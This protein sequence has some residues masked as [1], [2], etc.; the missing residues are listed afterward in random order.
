[1]PY[2]RDGTATH[3]DGSAGFAFSRANFLPESRDEQQPLIGGGGRFVMLFDGRID[4]REDLIADLDVTAGLARAPDCMV[5]M[6]CWEAWGKRLTSRLIG[7]FA[8]IVWDRVEHCLF[9]ARDHLGLRPLS[10]HVSPDVVVISNVPNALFASGLVQRE[11]DRQ[12][13]ADVLVENYKDPVR[14]LFRHVE[15]VP[16]AHWLTVSR[17]TVGMERYWSLNPERSIRLPRDENYVEAADELLRKAVAP[18][19]RSTGLVGSEISS[20]LDSPSIAVTALELLGP[21]RKL[22]VFTLVPEPTWRQTPHARHLEDEAP[23]VREIAHMHPNMEPCFLPAQGVPSD[24]GTDDRLRHMPMLPRSPVSMSV[25]HDVYE[26]AKAR[27]VTTLLNGAQGNL[28][29]SWAGRGAYNEWLRAGQLGKLLGELRL[30]ARSPLEMIRRFFGL[31]VIPGAPA[32]MQRL[33]KRL[34]GGQSP[35]WG[36]WQSFSLINPDFAAHMRVEERAADLGWNFLDDYTDLRRFRADMLTCD[37]AQEFGDFYLGLE[38]LHGITTRLPLLDVRLVEWC[39][40]LPEEQFLQHGEGR[41]LIK[42]LMKNRLPANVLNDRRRGLQIAD[43]HSS[44]TRDLPRLKEQLE[45]IAE[46]PEVAE[47]LN[48]PLM[49]KLLDTWPEKTPDIDH[50][51]YFQLQFS[52]PHA[53]SVGRFMRHLKGANL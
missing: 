4:N 39:F 2:G 30:V 37:T 20:G 10:Y 34:R 17:D 51:L 32:W 13:L 50:P 52:L 6:R 53:L 7:D 25:W 29:I 45:V 27:G 1:M 18:R 38:A 19:L 24:R 46:D 11:P 14:S 48:I 12:K 41:W 28:T 5:A 16:A 26:A 21:K 35:Q 8:L 9:A 23:L 15:R 49:K 42:R 33:H 47:M 22:P 40:A 31:A 44:M 3:I 36:T 43:W